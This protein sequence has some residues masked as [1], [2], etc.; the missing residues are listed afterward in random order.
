M[1]LNISLGFKRTG[2]SA[3]TLQ[4]SRKIDVFVLLSESNFETSHIV[5]GHDSALY[6]VYIGVNR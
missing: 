5:P 4:F 6:R 3:L 2:E 1:G